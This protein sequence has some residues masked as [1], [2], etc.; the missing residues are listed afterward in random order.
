MALSL[1]GEYRPF[2]EIG[3]A[4]LK[5]EADAR[6]INLTEADAQRVGA[7]L[8]S[9]PPFREVERS[10]SQLQK[11]N[12]RLAV[13]TNS[14]SQDAR[15]QLSHSGLSKYFDRVLSVGEVGRFKP[16]R[17]PY[18]LAA[19][20]ME[21]ETHQILMVA[22]HPWDLMG[23][24]AAGCRTAFIQ[25]PGKALFPGA[26]KPTYVARDLADLAAQ[27][28]SVY[29]QSRS[30]VIPTLAVTGALSVVALAALSLRA[31]STEH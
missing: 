11:A 9:L 10:L 22:A 31:G 15:E 8:R 4:V 25:R 5:M 3:R 28:R 7:A 2:S 27:L 6:G 26:L 29:G 16:S 21:V 14:A 12:F 17:E 1:V 19:R 23:A 20:S 18:E 30:R 24:A 13:L